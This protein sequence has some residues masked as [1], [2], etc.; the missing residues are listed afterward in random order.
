MPTRVR[1]RLGLYRMSGTCPDITSH[2]QPQFQKKKK[3]TKSK[4]ESKLPSVYCL[5]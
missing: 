3:M 1:K 5:L 4:T 2:A